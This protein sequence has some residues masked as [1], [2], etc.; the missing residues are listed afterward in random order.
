[1]DSEDFFSIFNDDLLIDCWPG[2]GLI[3][4]LADYEKMPEGPKLTVE[5]LMADGF[6]ARPF[7]HCYLAEV[8]K[9]IDEKEDSSKVRVKTDH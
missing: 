7:F 3:Q 1:M 8:D 4:E 2:R 6:G 5:D 9:G